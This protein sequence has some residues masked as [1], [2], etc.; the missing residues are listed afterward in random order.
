[1]HVGFLLLLGFALIA[2]LQRRDAR[3]GRPGS[4]CSGV[5]GFGTGLYNWV[6]YA[7]LIRR[8]RL[9]DHGRPRGR[10]RSSSCSSS[11]RRGG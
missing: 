8:A 5:L 11:R 3:G 2:N 7:E 9:P 10:A 4:G 6:F 1:M